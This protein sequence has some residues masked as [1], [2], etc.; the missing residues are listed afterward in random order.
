MEGPQLKPLVF[1]IPW[2]ALCSDNR[3][4]KFRFVLSDQY[5]NAKLEVG[6][7]AAAAAKTSGW[8]VVD[9]AVGV[10]VLVQEPDRRRRDLNFG[11]NLKDGITQ[12]AG[13]WRDDSQVREERWKFIAPDKH[14]AGATITIWRLDDVAPMGVLVH[15]PVC[16]RCAGASGVPRHKGT[17]NRRTT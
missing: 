13:V 7:L 9:G 4:Y 1:R 10:Y 6:K 2:V 14:N 15:G 8:P 3:K 12:G 5:R 16:P 11:K 17:R